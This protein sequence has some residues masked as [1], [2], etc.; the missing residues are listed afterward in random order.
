M[1]TFANNDFSVSLNAHQSALYRI[2]PLNR[3]Q[4]SSLDISSRNVGD[5][6]YID[7]TLNGAPDSSS[8]VVIMCDD[9]ILGSQSVAKTKSVYYHIKKMTGTHTF[10]ALYSGTASEASCE[11]KSITLTA[12][13][14]ASVIN[15][16]KKDSSEMYAVD[17]KRLTIKP[18]H[19]IYIQ[20]GKAWMVD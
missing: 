20:N 18:V 12:T 6:V 7:V 2:T 11:S 10:K 15:D 13:K 14:I 4:G 1:G 3:A 16:K 8:Y 5:D 9:S 17:G 19:G